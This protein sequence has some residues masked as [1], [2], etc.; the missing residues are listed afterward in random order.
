MKDSNKADEKK[1]EDDYLQEIIREE[2]AKGN[3][4][5]TM[6]VKIAFIFF[7]LI[8]LIIIRVTLSQLTDSKTEDGLLLKEAIETPTFSKSGDQILKKENV[9]IEQTDSLEEVTENENN[10]DDEVCT[11]AALLFKDQKAV[12]TKYSPNILF[13]NVHKKVNGTV[14][15]LRFFLKDG[16]NGNVP[17]YLVYQ[18]DSAENE[19]IVEN[20]P[21]KKGKLFNKIEKARGDILYDSEAYE[22]R[23]NNDIFVRYENG[24]LKELQGLLDIEA[25]ERFPLDCIY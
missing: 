14:Y 12:K 17:T 11:K 18:E 2:Q 20:S 8:I 21:E 24:E 4:K 25:H 15:R 10:V 23:N 16:D 19:Y 1:K 6:P 22:L 5:L 9:N 3:S 7:I 13:K